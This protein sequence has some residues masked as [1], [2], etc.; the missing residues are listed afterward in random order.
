[1][2]LVVPCGIG[3]GLAGVLL[4]LGFVNHCSMERGARRTW[5]QVLGIAGYIVAGVAMFLTVTML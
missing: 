4:I 2:A 3:A 1:M 5:N